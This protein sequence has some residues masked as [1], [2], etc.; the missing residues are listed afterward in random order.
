MMFTQDPFNPVGFGDEALQGRQVRLEGEFL[1]TS[2]S[3]INLQQIFWVKVELKSLFSSKE[4][5]KKYISVL[6]FYML[7]TFMDC[8]NWIGLVALSKESHYK[9]DKIF[10]KGLDFI[11]K[12]FLVLQVLGIFFELRE[13]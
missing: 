1:F 12:W 11:W 13:E 3:G 5:W 9:S 8:C 2:T 6:R 7:F 4:R 10:A